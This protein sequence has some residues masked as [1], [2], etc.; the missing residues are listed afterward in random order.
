MHQSVKTVKHSNRRHFKQVW[1][2]LLSAGLFLFVLLYLV[3]ITIT[4]S[5]RPLI[6]QW[7][8]QQQAQQQQHVQRQHTAA[9]YCQNSCFKARDGVC[10][11][12]RPSLD[13][14]K[15]Q[16]HWKLMRPQQQQQTALPPGVSAVHCDL[17]TDC[18]DCGPWEGQQADAAWS[19]AQLPIAFLRLHNISVRAR[20]TSQA[21]LPANFTFAFTDPS[22]DVD[23]SRYVQNEGLLEV[24]ISQVFH[25]LLSSQCLGGPQ[26]A[27]VADVGANFGWFSLL[28]ATL[29]CR[30]IAWE[31]VPQFR[32]FFSYN[33]ARN[34]LAHM[35][36]VRPTVVAD[37]PGSKQ[38]VLVP[39]KGIWGTA[40]IAGA[41]LDQSE[42]SSTTTPL[43][44]VEVNAESL[45]LLLAGQHIKLMK[46]DVEGYEPSVLSTAKGLLASGAIDNI[47]LEYSPGMLER[48]ER[49]SEM[50]RP[51][52]MLLDLTIAGFTLLHLPDEFTRVWA[53]GRGVGAPIP[54]LRHITQQNLQYDMWDTHT[55]SSG[56]LDPDAQKQFCPAMVKAK[57][58]HQGIPERLHPKSFHAMFSHN[59]NVWASRNNL[60]RDFSCPE[61]MICTAVAIAIALAH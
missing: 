6:T 17:G 9:S 26:D 47:V 59:T 61:R 51:P 18:S 2:A 40:S 60:V 34:N 45:D 14:A 25:T 36:T 5:W 55:F 23:V 4:I 44:R 7:A 49:W 28:A 41:N 52:Q 3:E 53:P 29:G 10:D 31:P 33:L 8:Q 12:G 43:Q 11:E 54:K 38:V 46:V 56:W 21:A 19:E 37:P 42:L 32:A 48:N 57:L 16:W 13:T 1:T 39:K 30:V 20:A 27:V 50:W 24:G 22:L 58:N 35:V 15:Q